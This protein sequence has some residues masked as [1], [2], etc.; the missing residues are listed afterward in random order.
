MPLPSFP[1]SLTLTGVDGTKLSPIVLLGEAGRGGRA[2]VYQAQ[3]ADGAVLA[4]KRLHP[5]LRTDAA[6]QAELK[7]EGQWLAV[8]AESAVVRLSPL[9]ALPEGPD[10]LA[11]EWLAGGSWLAALEAARIGLPERLVGLDQIADVL[12]ALAQLGQVH[13]DLKPRNVCCRDPTQPVLIDFG[14]TRAIDAGNRND[15][16]LAFA[17]LVWQVLSGQPLRPAAARR[18]L[19][20]VSVAR[21]RTEDA[22]SSQMLRGRIDRLL[23]TALDAQPSPDPKALINALSG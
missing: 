1:T 12:A 22:I 3:N 16:A 17:R 20:P 8:L 7:R 11:L 4:L 15:Q 23:A 2:T 14:Q 9:L 18:A 6:A 21:A 10:W 13:G 5:A 19:P